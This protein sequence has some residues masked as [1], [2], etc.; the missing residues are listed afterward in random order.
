MTVAPL[1]IVSAGAFPVFAGLG[2]DDLAS[3]AD[4]ATVA[5]LAAGKPLFRQGERGDALY[6]LADGRIEVLAREDGGP[7][8]RLATL[9][10]GAIL[11]EGA[12]LVDAPRTATAVAVADS[13]LWEISRPAFRDAVAERRPWAVVLLQA[14]AGVLA[15]RLATVDGR[16]L[17]LIASER[18]KDEATGAARVAELERLRHRLLSEWT[19]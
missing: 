14:I 18:E 9:G 15:E 17:A 13:H 1:D 12:V 16:L 11:G 4:H 8:Y 5:E 6:L 2:V 3:L 10:P 7:D 19:F